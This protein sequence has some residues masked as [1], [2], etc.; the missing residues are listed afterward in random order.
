MARPLPHE[1]PPL[2]GP[3]ARAMLVLWNP[4]ATLQDF[5]SV[6]EGDPVLTA[7]VL[8]SANSASSA[9]LDGVRTTSAAIVRIGLAELRRITSAALL[10]GEFDGL[11]GARLSV[12]EFWRHLL[13]TG[14]LAEAACTPAEES[15]SAFTAGLLHDIGRMSLAS[16]DP[17]GYGQVVELAANG[18]DVSEAERHIFG[19]THTETGA[20]LCE[21]W[22][23][24]EALTEVVGGHHDPAATGLAELV[25]DAREAAWSL[26]YGDGVIA[27]DAVTFE[28]GSPLAPAMMALGGPD[29][30][31]AR[32]RRCQ[33]ALQSR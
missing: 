17:V 26:G 11:Q 15:G 5:R 12:T 19:T 3:R 4:E 10:R 33:D 20:R 9:P 31:A 24:P 30:L 13:A 16:R 28:D 21:A 22:R 18:A 23:L 6:V 14:L 27:P 25:R 32:V 1:P 7:A 29:G 2:S 8:R